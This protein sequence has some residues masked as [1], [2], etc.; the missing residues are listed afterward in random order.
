[1]ILK[2]TS[3]KLNSPNVIFDSIGGEVLVINLKV[4]HYFRLKEDSSA[5][6]SLIMSGNTLTEIIEFLSIPESQ[7][8][9]ILKFTQELVSLD[10]VL[11]TEKIQGLQMNPQSLDCRNL[12]IEKFTDLEDILG[13]DP[14]HEVDESKGWPF[15]GSGEGIN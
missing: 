2:T 9:Q 4:G 13:L 15:S 12:T 1:M 10:L 14:I 8:D 6:W 5:L 11:E 7:H 3:F